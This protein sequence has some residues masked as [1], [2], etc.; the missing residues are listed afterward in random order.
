MAYTARALVRVSGV[1]FPEPST[2]EANT[3]TIV[4]SARNVD[5]YVIGSVIRHDVAKITMSWRWLSAEDWARVTS[6]FTNQFYHSVDFYDQTRASW[7]TREM[8]VGDRSAGMFRRDPETGEVL[9]FTNCT[10]S[11]VE[12]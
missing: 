1:D 11:L 6:L 2:Y 7:I 10:L 9:G 5:G 3:A 8:Y 4:D 12:V